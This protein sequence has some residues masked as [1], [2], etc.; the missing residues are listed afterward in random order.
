MPYTPGNF[1]AEHVYLQWGGKLPGGEAWSCGLR[2]AAVTPGNLINDAAF[3]ASA[4]PIIQAFHTSNSTAI[5]AAAKLSFLK[6]NVIKADG[7][8]K[9]DTTQ[10]TTYADIAGGGGAAATH[11]NQITLAVSLLTGFSRGPAHRGRF[12][13]PMPTHTLDANGLIDATSANNIKTV[14]QTMVDGLNGITSNLDV[15]VFSRKSGAATHRVVTACSVGRVMDTQR[16]RR[17]K[18]TELY[19]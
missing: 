15:A 16:R 19:N 7:H 11:P 18:Q 4:K 8:Y 9:F 2:M 17:R 6:V 3:L 13:Y 1:D 14:A 12:Y 10:E 5:A